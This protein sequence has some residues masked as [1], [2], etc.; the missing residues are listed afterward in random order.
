MRSVAIALCIWAPTAAAALRRGCALGSL[1]HHWLS[2]DAHHRPISWAPITEAKLQELIAA[3]DHDGDGQVDYKEF[4][5]VLARDTVAPAA[6]GKRDMQAEEAM[7]VE[8]TTF[9]GGP[10]VKNIKA[11]I[12]S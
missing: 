2:T 4:V 3:C 1:G 10:K 11:S 12:N 6:L 7:G 9:A 8:K 5:D